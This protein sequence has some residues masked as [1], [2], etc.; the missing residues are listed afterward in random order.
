MLLE[1]EVLNLCSKFTGDTPCQSV[2]LIKLLCN[3]IEITLRHGCSP[4]NLLHIFR[5]PFIRT[6]TEGC[7]GRNGKTYIE[8]MRTFI[9][10]HMLTGIVVKPELNQYWSTNPLIKTSFSNVVCQRCFF[11]LIREFLHFNDNV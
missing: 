4:I 10:F 8:E 7:F 3:F 1:K 5:T 11:S 6:P 2:I 9:S